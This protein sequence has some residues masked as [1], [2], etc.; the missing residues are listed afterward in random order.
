MSL[1]L[2][3]RGSHFATIISVYDPPTT[4]SDEGMNKFYE[5][6]NALLV[7]APKT[8]K[9]FALGDFNDPLRHRPCCLERSAGC[10]LVQQ[11]LLEM[12]DVWM[13]RKTEE[14]QGYADRNEWT[15]FFTAIRTVCGLTSKGTDPL[16]SADRSTLLTEKTQIL[17]QWTEHFRGVSNRPSIIS[18]AAT[19]CLPQVE[20]KA[21]LNLPPSQ[22]NHW[23]RA[24]TF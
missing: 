13:V 17:Q 19:A 3:L 18:D 20:T 23:G 21:D 1:C 12:Q 22:R 5:D 11:Q 6:L 8:D 7:P 15:N 24:T 10:H 14:V 4:S 2:S 16:L 9:L